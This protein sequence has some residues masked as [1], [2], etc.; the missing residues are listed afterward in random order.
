[1]DNGR[2]LDRTIYKKR[3]AKCPLF[4]AFFLGEGLVQKGEGLL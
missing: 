4:I 3:A 1:M 2:F